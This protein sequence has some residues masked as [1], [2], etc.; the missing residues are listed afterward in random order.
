MGYTFGDNQE[1]SR[2]LHRLAEVYEPVTRALLKAVRSACSSIRFELALD[3]GCGPGWSTRLIELTLSPKRIVG[4]EASEA[5]V[6]EARSN[7]PHLE[8]IR[9]DVLTIPF[10]VR[11]VDFIFCRFLLT[12]LP[13]PRVALESWAHAARPGA[14]LAIHE[15]ETLHSTHPVLS[16]YYEMVAQMQKHHG[17]DLNVGALLDHAFTGTDWCVLHSESVI[18]E[19]SAREMAQLHAANLRTWG[20]NDF[21]IQAFDR[22]EMDQLENELDL[23][24]SGCREAG[25]VYNTAKQMI[26]QLT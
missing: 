15:T 21:A 16:R 1:A 12:H 7:H 26:A 13:S 2:R 4:L 24:A 8:F 18:L 11:N 9:H 20:S 17:Q 3:L 19:K 10:P 22:R 14:L 23:I 25:V 6:A 5:Y